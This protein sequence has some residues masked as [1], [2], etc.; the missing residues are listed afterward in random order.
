[1]LEDWEYGEPT[2]KGYDGAESEGRRTDEAIK[3]CKQCDRCWEIDKYLSRQGNNTKA[4]RLII[5]HYV[6]FPTYGK[7]REVCPRCK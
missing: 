1:M 7:E 5:H 6:D 3:Y 4:K 2:T